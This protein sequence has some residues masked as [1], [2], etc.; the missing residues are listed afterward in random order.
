MNRLANVAAYCF[1]RSNER[2]RREVKTI[3]MLKCR[4]FYKIGYAKNFRE[5]FY[6][7]AVHNPHD[8]SI[9]KCYDTTEY[10]GFEE[11]VF[12]SYGDKHH[13]GEWFRFSDDDV[14][15]IIDKWF[16]SNSTDN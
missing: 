10:S 5:R 4:E 15:I 8:V 11:Y 1:R 3:Y 14:Q 9:V 12:K 2:A 16:T 13:R 7:Y 6:N